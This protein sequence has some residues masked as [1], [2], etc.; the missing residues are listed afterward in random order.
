MSSI[1][2]PHL[3]KGQNADEMDRWCCT[4]A[5]QR[6]MS[7]ASDLLLGPVAPKCYW[8]RPCEVRHVS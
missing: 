1:S 5:R 6:E 8:R 7:P 4:I 2:R 3:L